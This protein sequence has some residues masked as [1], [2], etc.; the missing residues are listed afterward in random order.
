MAEPCHGRCKCE[1]WCSSNPGIFG[2]GCTRWCCSTFGCSLK[3]PSQVTAGPKFRFYIKAF[4]V[5][6]TNRNTLKLLDGHLSLTALLKQPPPPPGSASQQCASCGNLREQLPRDVLSMGNT[7]SHHH[8]AKG[9]QP[10]GASQPC[11]AVLQVGACEAWWS[12]LPDGKGWGNHG[13][14]AEIL[15]DRAESPVGLLGGWKALETGTQRS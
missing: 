13:L 3:R 9:Q 12:G 7:I 6:G 4:L 10:P 5:L 8:C 2:T 14:P 15:K 11:L 1:R